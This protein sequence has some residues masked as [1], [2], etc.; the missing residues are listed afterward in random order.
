VIHK[1]THEP[2]I[3]EEEAQ[4]ILEMLATT[5]KRRKR[6]GNNYTYMLSGILFAPKGEAWWGDCGYYRLG[7]TVR[8]AA[9]NVDKA[10]L[11]NVREYATSPAVAE[12]LQSTTR[13]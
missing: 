10:I 8:V 3:S 6:N 9:H 11:E 2:L 12:A 5:S 1:N 13:K 7:K 4:Q